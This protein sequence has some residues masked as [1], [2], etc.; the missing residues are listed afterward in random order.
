[1]NNIYFFIFYINVLV[2]EI[3]LN[4]I[5]TIFKYENIY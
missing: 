5:C 3:L 1:M 4:K 2:F